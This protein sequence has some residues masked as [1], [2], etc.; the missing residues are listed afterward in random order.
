MKIGINAS[1]IRKP[2]T[3]IGQVSLNFVKELAKTNTQDTFILYLE[4]PLPKDLNLP[5]NF[6]VRVF[7]PL[8]KRDDLIRKIWWEKRMLSKKAKKDKCDVFFSLYQCPTILSRKIKHIMLVH[9]L[10]PRIFPEYLNNS[11]K[12]K[13]QKLSEK[14]I[15]KADKIIA[16]SKKTEKNL[17]QILKILGNKIAISYPDVDPLYKKIPSQE[18]ISAVLEKYDLSPG[19]ILGGVG[20][21]KRKNITN[22]MKAYQKILKKNEK[23]QFLP[24]LPELAIIGKPMPELAPLITDIEKL[25][26]KLNLTKQVKLLGFVP[27]K[28]MPTLY[29]QASLFIYPSLYEGFGLPVLEAMNQKTAVITSKTSSLPEVG[30][31]AVLYCNP[32]DFMEIFYVMQKVLISESLRKTLEERG[33][34]RAQSF[35]WQ[36]FIKKFLN[37]TQSI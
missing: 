33:G 14:G 9:D 30:R 36:V 31:D 29:N 10:I 3:G 24:V 34:K 15:K 20:L 32:K 6:E 13:Y 18:K 5:S 22:L 23:K 17:I 1:F 2:E 28:D 35:S 7:L 27:Q 26:K 11:R 21:D 12:R 4:E 25:I 8:W 19:Y 37:L 16:I